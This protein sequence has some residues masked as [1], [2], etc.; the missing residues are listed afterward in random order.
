MA[1]ASLIVSGIL[2]GAILSANGTYERGADVDLSPA[3]YHPNGL[4]KICKFD[5][6]SWYAI[7]WHEVSNGDSDAELWEFRWDSEFE[8]RAGIYGEPYPT[9]TT[10]AVQTSTN[11][12]MSQKYTIQ[13]EEGAVLDV[14]PA[15]GTI[16]VRS[17][18]GGS[19]R[20]AME[21]I[22][23]DET[24]GISSEVQAALDAKQPLDGNGFAVAGLPAAAD[25]EGRAVYCS[26]GAAGSPCLAISDG[27][28]WLRVTLGA[29]VATE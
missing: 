1:F 23:E 9:I 20:L 12:H 19:G 7:Y 22:G 13:T 28:D 26:D 8:I 16:R 21:G 10:V 18:T 24:S 29:A 11:N 15:T 25:N 4:W 17:T 2:A 3:Y 14:Y 5:G 27:T 6:R